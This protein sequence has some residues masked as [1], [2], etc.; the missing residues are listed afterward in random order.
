MV[1]PLLDEHGLPFGS[2]TLQYRGGAD[3]RAT[4]P[5]STAHAAGS[6]G[7]W[8]REERCLLDVVASALSTYMRRREAN[9]L[10][11]SIL[12]PTVVAQILAGEPVQ[13]SHPRVTILFTDIVGFTAIAD[14]RTP[15]QVMEMLSETSHAVLDGMLT[16]GV[17]PRVVSA[18]AGSI[19]MCPWGLVACEKNEEQH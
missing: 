12:P 9:R 19:L 6:T 5:T 2:V 3:A 17:K 16:Q 15:A 14:S 7:P 10:L 13:R 4:C 11:G 1:A 8:L 18:G